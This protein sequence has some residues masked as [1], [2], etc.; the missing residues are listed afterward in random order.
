M[1]VGMLF[2]TVGYAQRQK[3]EVDVHVTV[4]P[5]ATIEVERV[6]FYAR[7]ALSGHQGIY[8]GDGRRAGPYSKARYDGWDQYSIVEQDMG[9][10]IFWVTANLPVMIEFESFRPEDLSNWLASPT[11]IQVWKRGEDILSPESEI[12][13][14]IK[15]GGT[16]LSTKGSIHHAPG[17]TEYI[18]AVAILIESIAQQP[19]GTY[20]IPVYLTVNPSF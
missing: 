2:T 4:H 16:P 19:A 5:M 12:G 15:V 8:I 18:L 7:N 1:V 14:N 9:S 17:K 6:P 3:A 20:T 13:K 11:A 10:G